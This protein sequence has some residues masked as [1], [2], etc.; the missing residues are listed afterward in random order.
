MQEAVEVM[1]RIEAAAVVMS[2][3][4]DAEA[5]QGLADE[6]TRLFMHLKILQSIYRLS[7]IFTVKQADKCVAHLV[8]QL[9][10]CRLCCR[11]HICC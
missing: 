1:Q 10:E 2:G 11:R 9:P 8:D 5:K 7:F 6:A 3:W 4:E